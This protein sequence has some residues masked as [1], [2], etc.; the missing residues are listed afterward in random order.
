VAVRHI[1]TEARDDVP[2]EVNSRQLYV[3]EAACVTCVCDMCVCVRVCVPACDM[4]CVVVVCVRHACSGGVT[5][6]DEV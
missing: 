2:G 3:H 5:R 6:C 4:V 1:S